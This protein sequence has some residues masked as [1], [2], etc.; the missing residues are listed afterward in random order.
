M[1][2]M[3]E[4]NSPAIRV[5]LIDDQEIV[6]EAIRNMLL[7]EEDI[8]LY[9]C[10][11]PTEAIRMAEKIHPT[12]ILQDLVMP[13][14]DGLQL[15]R[16]LRAH[17]RTKDVPMIVLSSQEDPATKA[18]AFQAG[19]NDYLVKLPDRIELLARLRYHSSAYQR[20][21][22]RNQAYSQLRESQEILERDLADAAEYV[23]SSLPL[24]LETS[25]LQIDW[26]FIPSAALGGDSFGYHWLDH[27]HFALYL[28]DVC[29]HGIGPA[30]LSVSVANVLRQQILLQID[31][32]DPAQVLYGL[33][34]N[35]QMDQHRNMFFTIWYGVYRV[36][37]R[38]LFYASGGH[39]PAILVRADS[40]KPTERLGT[41]GLMIG[42]LP[43]T[44][45]RAMQVEVGVGD[46]LFVFSDGLCEI[47]YP[48]GHMVEFDRIIA[49]M[50]ALKGRMDLD[51]LL[52]FAQ[53]VHGSMHFS[54]DMSFIEV[55][56]GV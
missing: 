19:A 35:F 27:N 44:E 56:F 43:Q 14:M 3:V 4:G 16:Y 29:G 25:L 47:F 6:A 36:S 20:L 52:K 22:E 9:A 46:S 55:I 26:R 50:E 2:L 8:A 13:Q 10:Q 31:F 34:Q 51:Q 54:D 53:E 23:R 45:Y 15:T 33:N 49:E 32:K 40:T 42:G 41:P 11:D 39:P 24:P 28:L 30:L 1:T 12:V 5:L 21:V 7:D 37:D 48:D 17:P 18:S 38:Q